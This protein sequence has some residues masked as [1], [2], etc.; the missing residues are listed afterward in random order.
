M[1]NE[2]MEKAFNEQINKELYSEYLYLGMKA[3]FAELNLKGVVPLI[4]GLSIAIN[5][6]FP[7]LSKR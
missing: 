7:P 2:K 3:F 6:I 1:I 5:S 4:S